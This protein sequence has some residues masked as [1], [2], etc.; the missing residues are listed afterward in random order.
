MR[1]FGMKY[2]KLAP[3]LPELPVTPEIQ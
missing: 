1:A 2:Q 3:K